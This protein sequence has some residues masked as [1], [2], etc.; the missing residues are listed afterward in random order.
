M[1]SIKKNFCNTELC[2]LKNIFFENNLRSKTTSLAA[3]ELQLSIKQQLSFHGQNNF[4]KWPYGYIKP[5]L[6]TK[7]SINVS[8]LYKQ[9]K[10]IKLRQFECFLW[11]A[12]EQKMYREPNKRLLDTIFLRFTTENHSK[13]RNVKQNLY[14]THVI[15]KKLPKHFKMLREFLHVLN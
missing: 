13:W 4:G 2:W 6:K 9:L 11:N 10:I 15:K 1:N 3:W 12:M 14:R 8:S 5:A 7:L